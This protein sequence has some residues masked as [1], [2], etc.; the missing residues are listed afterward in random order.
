MSVEWY[1]NLQKELLFFGAW[2]VVFW[3]RLRLFDRI[4]A[5]DGNIF[6]DFAF[7]L[8]GF[9]AFFK[10]GEG[11]FDGDEIDFGVGLFDEFDEII[12]VAVH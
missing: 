4:R 9:E 10:F 7:I 2:S 11:D 6:G 8:K 1:T 5:G 3:R 12:T